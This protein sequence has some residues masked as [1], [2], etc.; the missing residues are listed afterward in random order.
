MVPL[1]TTA[2]H[3]AASWFDGDERVGLSGRYRKKKD[4]DFA[5]N[6]PAGIFPLLFYFLFFLL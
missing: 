6:P 5:Q 1:S 3:G 2:P 4:Y